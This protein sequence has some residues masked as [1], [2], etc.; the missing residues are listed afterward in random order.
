MNIHNKFFN[1]VSNSHTM[2]KTQTVTL[3]AVLV[4]ISSITIASA[5]SSWQIIVPKTVEVDKKNS[6]TT[7]LS[8]IVKDTVPRQ[9]DQLAGF[10]WLYEP[11]TTKDTAFAITTHDADLDGDGSNDVRDSLQNKDG[12]HAH[13]VLLG[14]TTRAG[15][16]CI[17]EIRDAPNTGIAL[18]QE[19]IRVQVRNDELSGKVLPRAVAFSITPDRECPIT[20]PTKDVIHGGLP[21][22]IKIESS[23]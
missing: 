11:K 5:T 3:L 9:T 14:H 17:T 12:W 10:A 16:I 2:N 7:E 21:L 4:V 8:L 15:N 20:I 6:Q 19:E 22:A 13:N 18:N 23:G 1:L